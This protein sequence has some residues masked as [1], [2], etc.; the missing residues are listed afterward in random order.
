LQYRN[1]IAKI[2][3]TMQLFRSCNYQSVE[4]KE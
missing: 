2:Q 4:T 1:A 3:L